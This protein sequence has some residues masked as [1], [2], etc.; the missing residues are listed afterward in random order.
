MKNKT[1]ILLLLILPIGLLA[2]SRKK[3]RHKR[4]LK[5]QLSVTFD[6]GKSGAR[7]QSMQ[8]SIA[9]EFGREEAKIWDNDKGHFY[10]IGLS[11]A[12]NKNLDLLGGLAWNEFSI[13]QIDGFNYSSCDP[14]LYGATTVVSVER[15]V[16]L[17]S[18]ELPLAMRYRFQFGKLQVY[19]SAGIRLISYGQKRQ[20]I[21]ILLDNGIVA[22]HRDNDIDLEH[23]LKT[24]VAATFNVGAAYS[25]HRR[26]MVRAEFFQHY[27]LRAD[28]LMDRYSQTRVH[29]LGLTIGLEYALSL[30]RR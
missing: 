12:L 19:P 4:V 14:T 11:Y 13:T 2:Q 23:N 21:N 16:D 29:N 27:R 20:K 17:N 24:N 8:N 26:L 9:A 10:Q 25:I 7:L 6:Y 1:L 15:V 5:P 28:E 30:R 22:D 18:F 3:V